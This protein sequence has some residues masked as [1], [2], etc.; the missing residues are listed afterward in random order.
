MKN[1]SENYNNNTNN[2]FPLLKKRNTHMKGGRQKAFSMSE[3]TLIQHCQETF[4]DYINDGLD[5]IKTRRKRKFGLHSW[6]T[7]I[8]IQNDL[9]RDENKVKSH[10]SKIVKNKF[11]DK[12]VQKMIKKYLDAHNQQDH[13]NNTDQEYISNYSEVEEVE[14]EEVKVKNIKYTDFHHTKYKRYSPGIKFNKDLAERI[15]K[16]QEEEALSKMN[17]KNNINTNIEDE[18]LKEIF[19]EMSSITS[20]ILIFREYFDEIFLKK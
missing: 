17:P 10:V 20:K 5:R 13:Y 19:S 2:E 18:E 3:D 9:Y 6:I 12:H 4:S 7:K 14:E 15:K 16:Q 11:M 1:N 8:L